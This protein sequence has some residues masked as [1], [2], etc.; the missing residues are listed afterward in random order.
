M[1]RQRC[2]GSSARLFAVPPDTTS[3]ELVAAFCAEGAGDE[4]GLRAAAAALDEG[5]D[6]DRRRGA[7]LARWCEQPGARAA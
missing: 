3:D 2:G 4:A 7:V 1:A 6:A 5:S